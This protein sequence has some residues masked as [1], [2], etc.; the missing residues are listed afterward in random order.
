MI[1]ML[2][3]S[4]KDP[5]LLMDKQVLESALLL[6]VK[7]L[8]HDLEEVASQDWK[9]IF[10]FKEELSDTIHQTVVLLGQWLFNCLLGLL[11]ILPGQLRFC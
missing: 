1:E 9:R 10:I 5:T 8:L 4:V 3:E 2:E 7:E 6:L 11:V